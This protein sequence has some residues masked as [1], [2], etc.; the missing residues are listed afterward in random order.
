MAD[1]M[2]PEQELIAAVD[3]F[4]ACVV[5]EAPFAA[6]NLRAAR[7]R[8]ATLVAE[9]GADA[10]K[11]EIVS[12]LLGMYGGMGSVNDFPWSRAGEIAK[13][14]L[15]DALIVARGRYDPATFGPRHDPDDYPAVAVGTRVRLIPG[16]TVHV[17]VRSGK[18][19]EVAERDARPGVVWTVCAV[20][21]PDATGM[22]VY[23]LQRG[24]RFMSAR[25]EAFVPA[26]GSGG[27]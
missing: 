11:N 22:P 21:P 19:T 3:R 14:G 13:N 9:G 12:A 7:D 15:W 1:L 4:L 18:R 5:V 20:H 8:L 2:D 26:A 17:D 23:Q 27:R 6:D 16:R 10:A 25:A 24:N